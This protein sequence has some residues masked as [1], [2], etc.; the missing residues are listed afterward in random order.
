MDQIIR[1]LLEAARAEC[2]D[3]PKS[4][5][6][7]SSKVIQRVLRKTNDLSA[8]SKQALADDL[9]EI[10]PAVERYYDILVRLVQGCQQLLEGQGNFGGVCYG[11]YPA[12]HPRYTL[13]RITAQ[14]VQFLA[15]PPP[16]EYMSG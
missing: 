7:K 11:Y 5:F 10:T 3:P 16:Q 13:C 14:G 8:A 9:V 4:K 6:K 15:D 12:A 2:G 1:L